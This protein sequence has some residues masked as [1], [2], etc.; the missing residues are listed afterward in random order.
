MEKLQNRSEFIR[1]IPD[2][3]DVFSTEQ[4]VAALEN[5]VVRKRFLRNYR[6]A[7]V[8][9][10]LKEY[11]LVAFMQT[12]NDRLWPYAILQSSLIGFPTTL[13][14]THWASDTWRHY[15]LWSCVRVC[16]RWPSCLFGIDDLPRTIERCPLCDKR[17]FDVRH[18]LQFCPGTHHLYACWALGAGYPMDA[19]HDINW[20]LFRLELFG[21]R[22]GNIDP[23]ISLALARIHY[24]GKS[25]G[26]ILSAL[27]NVVTGYGVDDPIEDLLLEAQRG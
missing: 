4:L 10:V 23:S 13:L 25:I 7:H 5:K 26:T 24:V 18:A 27:P 14:D 20:F 1:A 6:R 2:I 21:G 11:D 9:P 17:D 8:E 19:R 16:G 15:Q 22:L 12:A 3:T